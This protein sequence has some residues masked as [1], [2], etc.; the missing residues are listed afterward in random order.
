LF[1][2]VQ[3]SLQISTFPLEDHRECS[4]MFVWVGVLL[5]Y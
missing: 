4:L 5:V 2:T 3:K 1:V